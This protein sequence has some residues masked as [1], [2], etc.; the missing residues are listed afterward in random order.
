VR[1]ARAAY[2]VAAREIDW[3]QAD[4]NY[5]VLHCGSREHLVR[6]TLEA[7]TQ[8][9]DPSEFARINRSTVVNLDRVRELRPRSHGEFDLV[10][11]S[12]RELI[13]SRRYVSPVL[14]KFVP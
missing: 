14:D 9:L 1:G 3:I 11:D 7:F 2:F 13:W 10:L 6:S 4:R 8:R 12:G 5:L